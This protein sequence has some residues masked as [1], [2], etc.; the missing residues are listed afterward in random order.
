VRVPRQPEAV[1]VQPE[2]VKLDGWRYA[3]G[4]IDL[5][6][7]QFDVHQMIVIHLGRPQ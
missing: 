3:D 2:D 1:F 5:T 7:P 6:A 4:R